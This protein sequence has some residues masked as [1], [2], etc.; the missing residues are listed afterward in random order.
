V[1]R[2]EAGARVLLRPRAQDVGCVREQNRAPCLTDERSGSYRRT[3]QYITYMIA[4]LI[5]EALFAVALVVPALLL[6]LL[7]EALGAPPAVVWPVGLLVVV[8]LVSSLWLAR[9]AAH[10]LAYQDELFF[11]AAKTALQLAR[12]ELASLPLVGP[13]FTSRPKPPP[14]DD[15]GP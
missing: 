1:L 7:V 13:L 8:A 5:Y 12:L 11:Q 9:T 15:W 3:V 10:S 4:T 6:T 2:T 14:P